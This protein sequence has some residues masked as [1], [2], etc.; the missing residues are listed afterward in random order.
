MTITLSPADMSNPTPVLAAIPSGT[1]RER[2]TVVLPGGEFETDLTFNVEGKRFW[3]LIGGPT[4][5]HYPTYGPVANDGNYERRHLR[6]VNVSDFYLGGLKIHGPHTVKQVA[7]P[8]KARYDSTK[9]FQH[10]FQIGSSARVLV[11]DVEAFEIGGDGIYLNAVD[12]IQVLGFRVEFN[13]RQGFAGIDGDR[14]LFENVNVVNSARNALDFEPIG[15]RP[16]TAVERWVSHVMIRNSYLKGGVTLHRVSAVTLERNRI[17]QG[18][19]DVNNANELLSHRRYGIR[20]LNNVWPDLYTNSSK[21]TG[22]IQIQSVDGV[23]IRGNTCHR[24][25]ADIKTVNAPFVEMRAL[26]V[27]GHL[28]VRDNDISGFVTPFKWRNTI[29]PPGCVTTDIG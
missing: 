11:E 21:D 5:L 29:I 16:G 13:G 20:I 8:T 24:D 1:A 27:T 18:K 2:Q 14:W 12:D 26:P 9:A 17:G 4:T 7:D 23:E 19:I 22:P 15:H 6:L 25:P 10:G 28:I 3:N